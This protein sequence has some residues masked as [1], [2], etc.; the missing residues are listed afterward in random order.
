MISIITP[1]VRPEGLD[2]VK[3]ALK[4]Q[5]YTDY[6]WIVVMPEGERSPNDVWTLNKDY[7]RAIRQSKGDLIVS[8]QD[9]TSTPPDTL[10]RFYA[11]FELEP[12]TIVTAVGNKYSD[13]SFSV[14]MWQD[15]R[16]RSDQGTYYPCF[17]NDIE[18]NLCSISR[19]ALYDVGGFDESMDTRY[20][21][22]GISVLDRLNRV[23]GYDFKIDQTIRSYSTEHGRPSKWDENNWQ[24]HY[25]EKGTEYA[26]N[27]RLPYLDNP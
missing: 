4:K 2:L 23:G 15:P 13:E 17:W 5:T 3:K 7:N 8:W 11:H 12:K 9:Y 19:K 6:E 26:I 16:I 18:F 20:G 1:T 22:D 24:T 14:V 21:Y 27:P 10:E 25:H